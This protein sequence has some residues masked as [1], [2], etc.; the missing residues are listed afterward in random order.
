MRTPVLL[1][2]LVLAACGTQETEAQTAT[3]Q[4]RQQPLETRPANTTY[5]PALPGQTRA[6]LRTENVKFKVETLASGLEH[7]WGLDFLPGGRMLVTERAGRLRILGPDGALSEPIEGLP[8]VDA[9]GQ[10]GLLDV[11]VGP[12]GLVYWSYAQPREGGN[13]TAVARGRLVGDTMTDVQV[14]WEMKPT[15][16]SRLHFG[17]RLVFAPDGKL[18]ITT[19]ERSIMEG[20]MQAQQLDSAFG[21]VIR[22]NPDGSIPQDNPF[23]GRA[24]ALPEIW[25]IGHRNIQAAAIRPGT[26]ELWEA[27]HGPLG[28]DELNVVARG[29]DYGWPTISYG[30]EYRGGVIGEGLTQAPGMEQ[31]VY[32]WDPVIAPSGMAFYNADLFP[33][34]KGSLFIGG[35]KPPHLARLTLDGYRVVGEERLL[36]DLGLRI[37]D[38][39]VGPD[40][41]LYLLTDEDN[42]KVLRLVPAA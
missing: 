13:G 18:F 41:A 19:G 38:V 7:P 34:W 25:S 2:A 29:K 12:D 5:Q 39:N 37:R 16:A 23:V 4:V 11:A 15:L 14:I 35:M 1:A 8:A 24:G 10:G 26:S 31:P 33:A 40:G 17:S 20:R 9:E 22:I 42:G 27:E 32:Y 36:E 30:I 21:K 28:G 6:P 3:V